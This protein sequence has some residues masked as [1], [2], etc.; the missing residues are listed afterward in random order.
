MSRVYVDF[1]YEYD[2]DGFKHDGNRKIKLYGSPKA[3]PPPPQATSQTVTQVTVPEYAKPYME[4]MLGKSEALSNAPYQ[5]YKGQRIA[6]FDPMQE[7]AFEAAAN[8]G[9]AKQLGIGT[10]L[11][12]YGGLQAL[13]AGQQFNRMATDPRAMSQFMSPYQQNVTDMEKREAM[14]Q[15]G[16]AGTQRAFRQAGSGS[17]GGYRQ[18]IENAEA[19][20]NLMQQMG[21]IQTKG[22]Q[23]AY[24]QAMKN[25][26]FGSELGLRGAG[27]AT[28]AGATLG[29]LGQTQFGQQEAAMRAQAAA[30]GQRQALEQERLT[31]DYQDFLNQRNYQRQ[32]LAF[33]SDILR[34]APMQ[35]ATQSTYQAQPGMAA[36]I[37]QVGLGAYG[38]SQLMGSSKKEGGI[39]KGYA[40]GGVTTGADT[41]E[42]SAMVRK[43]GDEQ[44]TAMQEQAETAEDLAVI[45]AEQRRR[46]LVRNGAA[47]AQ[48]APEE[49]IKEQM[50]GEDAGL[51]ALPIDESMVAQFDPEASN[52]MA[53]GGIVAFAKGDKVEAPPPKD[54]SY[55]MGQLES[56]KY[57]PLSQA[58]KAGI[59]ANSL[60]EMQQY[61]GPDASIPL[62]KELTKEREMLGGEDRMRE[63]RGLAALEAAEA[64]AEPGVASDLTRFGRA[65]GKF[66][67]TV[68]AAKKDDAAA[69]RQ[70]LL[71]EI[72]NANAQ[73]AVRMGEF[74][75]AKQEAKAAQEAR[76]K[77]ADFEKDKTTKLATLTESK[78]GRQLQAS[79][80]LE[81]SRMALQGQMAQ[82]NK[83][84]INTRIYE[85]SIAKAFQ[86]WQ[87]DNP[88]KKPTE[89]DVANI[90]DKAGATYAERMKP[91]GGLPLKQQG[92]ELNAKDKATE[93]LQKWSEG[94]GSKAVRA[95]QRADKQAGISV[96]DPNS[97]TRKLMTE[98]YNLYYDR[99]RVD[100]GGGGG[101]GAGGEGKTISWDSIK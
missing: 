19:N 56:M 22:S 61:V 41:A 71:A 51:A 29:Q 58:E 85:D 79:V 35:Q 99:F 16:I 9:P 11:A 88:G 42:L 52:M 8:L 68:A 80:A 48:G 5:A 70:L 38:I 92:L 82:V 74:T 73:R 27:Q 78:E 81:Q 53:R 15:A 76:D 32:N 72:S 66:G 39:I 83:K 13:G 97:A 86:D 62:T 2:M 89:A 95:A 4:R 37:G 63:I 64:L 34:G 30:G 12:G 10:E 6:G 55:Y 50:V 98:Q 26:Q 40:A 7:Q 47:L 77:A 25:M 91:Y 36:Q 75:F 84:D 59:T 1:P 21:D 44:L 54:S 18:G 94:E 90:K 57:Q 31:Q 3:P 28:A 69:K 60:A 49:T 67:R 100:S 93:A 96:T 87:K 46:A 43:L 24:E 65:G 45:D 14:R 101:G 17:M 20:R 23:S 33:M